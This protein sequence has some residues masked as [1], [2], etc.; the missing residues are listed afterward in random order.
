MKLPIMIR[1]TCK[2]LLK[3]LAFVGSVVQQKSHVEESQHEQGKGSCP[4]KRQDVMPFQGCH[5]VML[6]LQFLSF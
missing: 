5:W 4:D 6:F 1:R 3:A 2:D